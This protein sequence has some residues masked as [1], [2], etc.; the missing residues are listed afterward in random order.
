VAVG[1]R[2]VG[3]FVAAGLA[4]WNW[5]VRSARSNG[6]GVGAGG[7]G[8]AALPAPPFRVAGQVLDDMPR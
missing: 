5:L 2:R 6:Q 8:D 1:A 4:S 3:G 7:E